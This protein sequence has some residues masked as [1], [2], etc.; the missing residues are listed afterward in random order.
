[1]QSWTFAAGRGP[2]YHCP[3]PQSWRPGHP[4]D[5]VLA[6]TKLMSP[7]ELSINKEPRPLGVWLS[8]VRAG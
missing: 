8:R 1:M 7:A 6:F 4:I 2:S 3:L 5:I